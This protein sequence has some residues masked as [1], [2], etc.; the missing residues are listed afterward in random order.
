MGRRKGHF[1]K[2]NST[3]YSLIQ[4]SAPAGEQPERLWIE[5]AKGVGVGRPDPDLAPE[6][7]G[8]ASS[9]YPPGHPLAFFAEQPDTALTDEQR[10]ETVDLGLPDDGYDYLQHLRDP[11][12]TAGLNSEQQPAVKSLP[13][14]TG[15]CG[16]IELLFGS[17]LDLE[18]RLP[19]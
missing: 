14:G 2:K 5:K 19:G 1:D 10:Q 16:V 17:Y 8:T 15:R 12:S 6:E 13:E 4:S 11:R 18:S 7:Q 3:T 9:Q